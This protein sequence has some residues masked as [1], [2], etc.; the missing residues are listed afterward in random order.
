MPWLEDPIAEQEALEGVD[1]HRSM[2]R[3]YDMVATEQLAV[4]I[5]TS[6]SLYPSTSAPLAVGATFAGVPSDDDLRAELEQT[7]ILGTNTRGGLDGF[8]AGVGDFIRGVT[9]TAALAFNGVY[10]ELINRPLRTAA[11][12]ISRSPSG[13]ILDPRTLGESYAASG[14]APL[15]SFGEMIAGLLNGEEINIGQGWLPKSKLS[16]PVETAL[17]QIR[18]DAELI[19]GFDKTAENEMFAR[20]GQQFGFV[21]QSTLSS[22]QQQMLF[23]SLPPPQVEKGLSAP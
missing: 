14:N 21:N 16:V 1:V 17:G 4:D 23:I 12:Q 3:F 6:A 2:L 13:L 18:A 8:V 7:E 19:G 5:A 20:Y 9:R 15:A 22:A 10:D 11:E